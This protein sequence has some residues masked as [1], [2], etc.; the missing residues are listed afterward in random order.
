MTNSQ[1]A[2]YIFFKLSLPSNTILKEFITN[3]NKMLPSEQFIVNNTFT[4]LTNKKLDLYIFECI[5]SSNDELYTINNIDSIEILQS[6]ITNLES[7]IEFNKII[8]N[9][10]KDQYWNIKNKCNPTKW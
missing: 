3:Y 10:L 1:I 5:N 7:I 9:D 8:I 4:A 6:K 2:D